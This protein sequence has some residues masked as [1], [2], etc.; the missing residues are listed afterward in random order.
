MATIHVNDKYV[1]TVKGNL[2]TIH[3]ELPI[4]MLG[5]DRQWSQQSPAP[6]PLG[7]MKGRI[8]SGSPNYTAG[9]DLSGKIWSQGENLHQAFDTQ[10]QKI[11]DFMFKIEQFL[12][13]TDETELANI[14]VQ[15]IQPY[16]SGDGPGTT[17]NTHTG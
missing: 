11:R 10:Q 2:D 4:V 6:L 16:L 14:S 17:T 3:S 8:L 1:E 9:W 7:E 15:E 13:A 12:T 5:R